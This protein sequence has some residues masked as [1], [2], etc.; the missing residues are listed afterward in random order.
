MKI[1]LAVDGS[2]Y[3]Q[4][5]LAYMAANPQLLAHASVTALSSKYGRTPAQIL[6]RYLTQNG[7]VPLSGTRSEVHMREDLAIFEFELNDGDCAALA[8]AL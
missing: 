7:V 1:L 2:Q 4:R 6:F 3:T 5:M 8:A